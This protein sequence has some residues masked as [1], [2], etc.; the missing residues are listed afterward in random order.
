MYLEVSY[1]VT[2][3][4]VTRCVISQDHLFREYFEVDVL[5]RK[6]FIMLFQR[7]ILGVLYYPAGILLYYRCH[8]YCHMEPFLNTFTTI[9]L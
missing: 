3:A 9:S 2:A 4:A 1:L 7:L 6:Y 5:C 8:L